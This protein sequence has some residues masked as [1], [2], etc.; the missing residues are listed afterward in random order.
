MDSMRV[1]QLRSKAEWK[2]RLVFWWRRK[3]T[4]KVRPETSEYK[5]ISKY[6]GDGHSLALFFMLT[7]Q[8]MKMP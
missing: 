8:G 4:E 2:D 3:P 7:R 1:D 6:E 5:G